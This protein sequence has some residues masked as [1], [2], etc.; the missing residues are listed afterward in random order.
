MALGYIDEAYSDLPT[1]KDTLPKLP[2]YAYT[3]CEAVRQFLL[4]D[5]GNDNAN[6]VTDT[7]AYSR[8]VELK[9]QNAE[10]EVI[11]TT[12]RKIF[13]KSPMFIS[14]SRYYL[15]LSQAQ[16]HTLRKTEMPSKL[17]ESFKDSLVLFLTRISSSDCRK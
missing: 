15:H 7:V 9:S 4:H 6:S 13:G 14:A 8:A 16:R 10:K 12:R 1:K 2:L 3:S 11:D 5:V 17:P